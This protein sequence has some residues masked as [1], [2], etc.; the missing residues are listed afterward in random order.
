MRTAKGTVK[1]FEDLSADECRD[2]WRLVEIPCLLSSGRNRDQV[3][4][5]S[6]GFHHG[7]TLRQA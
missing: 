5:R 2:I 1:N 3:T 4:C 7:D 6:L